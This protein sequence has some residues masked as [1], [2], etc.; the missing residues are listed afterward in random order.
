[1]KTYASF[2][3]RFF[4]AGIIFTLRQTPFFTRDWYSQDN[5]Y[6]LFMPYEAL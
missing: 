1:M 4:E 6:S 2:K 3:W 5:E